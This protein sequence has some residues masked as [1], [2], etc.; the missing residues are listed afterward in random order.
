MLP[1]V[2]RLDDM[3]AFLSLIPPAIVI[4][5]AVKTKKAFEAMV[6]GTLIGFAF[7]GGLQTP[8]MFAESILKQIVNPG[9][10]WVILFTLMVGGLLGLIQAAKASSAF[11]SFAMRYASSEKKTFMITLLLAL[12][13]YPDEYLRGMT[14]N[15]AMSNVYKKNKIPKEMFGFSIS[16]VG[17]PLVTLIPATTWSVYFSGL[18]EGAGI[19]KS[20]SGIAAYLNVIPLSFYPIFMLLLYVLAAFGFLPKLGGIKRAYEAVKDGTYDFEAYAVPDEEGSKASLFDFLLPLIVVIATSIIF[21]DMMAG[22]FMGGIVAFVLYTAKKYITVDEA[23]E[24]FWDGVK[25]MIIPM[26]IVVVSYSLAEV[27]HTLGFADVIYML[28]PFLIPEILP[29]LAFLLSCALCYYTGEFW[30]MAAIL[31][32]AML[33]LAVEFDVNVWLYTSAVF[34]GSVFGSNTCVYGD[35]NALLAECTDMKQVDIAMNNTPYALVVAGLP[36]IA[37]LIFGFIL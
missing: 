14:L 28:K 6:L 11:T 37:Y 2:E 15:T 19:A 5:L 20:G 27:M 8:S 34:G 26:A 35:Y 23:M 36:A 22:I 16:A 18:M 29:V 17:V 21:G 31:L 10:S 32:P 12:M 33:P 3:S 13:I 4:V 30:G 9:L 1:W 25:T 7:F 24:N